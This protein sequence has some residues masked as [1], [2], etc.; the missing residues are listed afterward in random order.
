MVEIVNG[1]FLALYSQI[2]LYDT[3]DRNSYPSWETGSEL[4]VFGDKGVA[5]STKGD[6]YISVIV[7]TEAPR[8]SD[9]VI[10][11]QGRIKVGKKGLTVG[12]ELAASTKQINWSEG[13]VSIEIFGNGQ[14]DEATEIVFVINKSEDRSPIM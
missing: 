5:V 7:C 11:G 8:T 2:G 12:N 1:S 6:T 13:P 10:Y 9:L 3:E 14:Q 4:V